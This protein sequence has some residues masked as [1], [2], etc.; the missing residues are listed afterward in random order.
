MTHA[1][2]RLLAAICAGL[3]LAAGMPAPAAAAD[4]PVKF[5]LDWKA[6]GPHAWFLLARDKGYFRQEGLDVTI[7]QGDGSAAAVTRIATGTYDA[8]F[9]DINALVQVA[10]QQPGKAPV[11]VSLLYNRAPFAIIAKADGPVKTLHDLEGRKV[12]TPSGSATFKLFPALAGKNGTDASKVNVVNAAPNLIEQLLVRGDADAIAQFAP[13]SYINFVAMGLDPR[14]DFRW[15]YY[16]DLGL[17]MYSNG[18][19]VSRKLMTEHPEAVR[20][21]LVAIHKAIREVAADPDAGIAA[22]SRAD[23]LTT[24]AI[25]KQRLLFTLRQQMQT[26]ETA[27]LGLGDLKDAR[28][29]ASIDTLAAAY[30]LAAKPPVGDIFNRG[31][32]PPKADRMLAPIPN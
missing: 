23:P 28:L 26:P 27:E 3:A 2:Y 11:M 19:I 22:V 32:L 8:G 25:E 10:A 5:I 12:A 24:P 14:K 30:G 16:S 21:L 15:F 1:L 9:G 4:L 6:Q 18:I 17:D 31:F 13:T 20:G 7:D 29:A